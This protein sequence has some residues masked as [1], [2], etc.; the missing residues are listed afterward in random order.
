MSP[1]S[2]N[3]VEADAVDNAEGERE[4]VKSP[5]SQPG[6]SACMLLHRGLRSTHV[7]KG[8]PGTWEISL[9]RRKPEP[10]SKAISQATR[11][12][13]KSECRSRSDDAGE[14]ARGTQPS[15][16][17]HRNTEPS[18]RKMEETKSSPTVSTKLQRIT[19]TARQHP[20]RAF[21]TLAHHID[22]AWLREAYRRTRK[23]GATGIDGRRACRGA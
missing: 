14:P 6:V 21:T 9:P 4:Q 19:E 17:R 20:E 11:G 5:G 16:G 22:I 23:D 13:E 2:R 7:H 12:R 10:R 8:C 15:K 18:E 3:Q 1:E